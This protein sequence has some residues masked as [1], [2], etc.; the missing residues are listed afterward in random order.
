MRAAL[1]LLALG[2]VAC[3]QSS[4][5][6]AELGGPDASPLPGS[7][8]DSGGAGAPTGGTS[9]SGGGTGGGATSGGTAGAGASNGGSSAGGGGT[10]GGATADGGASG[11]A[12]ASAS[13]PKTNGPTITCGGVPCQSPAQHCCITGEGSGN[14]PSFQCIPAA[15][16]CGITALERMCDAGEDCGAS[17]ICCASAG[18]VSTPSKCRT[19]C[20]S[21]EQRTCWTGNECGESGPFCCF[22]PGRPAGFCAA[23]AHPGATLCVK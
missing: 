19:E 10:A 20:L 8:G 17:E 5:G 6:W 2:L 7:G 23:T 15:V 11:A 12:G 13:A 18:F 21:F 14:P 22:F 3:A 9:S 4:G 16:G 1:S